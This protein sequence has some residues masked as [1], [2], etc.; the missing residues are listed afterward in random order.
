MR[1]RTRR[2]ADG[3][4]V[5]ALLD[6]ERGAIALSDVVPGFD[7]DLMGLWAHPAFP[8]LKSAMAEASDD[9]YFDPGPAGPPYRRPRKIWGIG[10]NYREHASDLAES[11]PEEP[12][13]FLKGDHTIV[14]QGD[15]IAIPV[16]SSHTT[17]EAELGLV[18]GRTCRN[19]SEE[20][21]L[22][23]IAGVCPILDQ[24]AEDILRRNPR[25]LTRAKNFPG[26]FSFGPDIVTLDEVLDQVGSL[27][28]IRVSTVLN[29]EVARENTIEN[30]RFGLR[31]LVS[32]HSKVMPLFPGDII[33]TGTPGAVKISPGDVVE[34]RISGVGTLSNPVV[35]ER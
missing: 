23:Y 2:T 11:V 22:D 21:A 5:P 15:E 31:Y 27:E 30:M 20:H 7:G 29:G 12:A 9:S 8:N 10:L 25:F 14:G 13:S 32:F 19:V 6:P 4:E 35:A 17:S 18:V 33:A 26:F 34:C 1:F 28:A 3:V 24:T 16:Q